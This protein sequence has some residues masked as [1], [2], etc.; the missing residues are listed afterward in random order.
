[1]LYSIPANDIEVILTAQKLAARGGWR[2]ELYDSD[3][4][5]TSANKPP[6]PWAVAD[7]EFAQPQHVVTFYDV[8]GKHET[9]IAGL[10][11]K[12]PDVTWTS[13][14]SNWGARLKVKEVK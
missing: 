7:N 13:L 9:V 12:W 5:I 4:P 11:W 10:M 3:R 6:G 14:T 8:D 2:F 1:M